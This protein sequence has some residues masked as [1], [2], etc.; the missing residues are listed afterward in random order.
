[1]MEGG[2]IIKGWHRATFLVTGEFCILLEMVAMQR[3]CSSVHP[4]TEPAFKACA[5][6][7]QCRCGCSLDMKTKGTSPCV[8]QSL[9]SSSPV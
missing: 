4:W 9:K 1:M 2:V 3:V 6:L 5:G 8:W 7:S